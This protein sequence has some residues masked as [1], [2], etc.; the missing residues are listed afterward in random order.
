V[1]AAAQAA[2]DA[3]RP[4][5]LILPTR[6]ARDHAR[7]ELARQRGACDPSAAVTFTGLAFRVLGSRGP[8]LASARE[9]DAILVEVLGQE[10]LPEH[11][12]A[13]RFRGFRS[14][15]L[16]IFFQV[17]SNPIGS[18]HDLSRKLRAARLEPARV[19]RLVGVYAGYREV[20]KQ[21]GLATEPDVLRLAAKALGQGR[22]ETSVSDLL[23]LDGF[24]DLSPRQLEFLT[25]LSSQA[26]E[27][28]VT[29]PVAP[30]GASSAFLK[31]ETVREDLRELGFEEEAR[32]GPGPDAD[33]PRPPALRRLAERLFVEGQAP[34]RLDDP[35]GLHVVRAASRRDEVAYALTRVREFVTADPARRWT[36]ALVIVPQLRRYRALIEQVGGELE[37]PVRV[38]GPL[39]LASSPLGQGALALM[40]AAAGLDLGQVITAAACPS[41]GLTPDQAD[42]VA[43]SAR[44][45]GL[46]TAASE[47]LW[48]ELAREVEGPGGELLQRTLELG[49]A[50]REATADDPTTASGGR[51]L[52]R[53][54]EQLLVPVNP[55]LLGATP[56]ARELAAAAAEVSARQELLALLGD[57]ER[58]GLP[59]RAAPGGVPG[60]LELV[61]RVEEE[62]RVTDHQ[63]RD[64]RRHVLHVVDPRDA[65]AWEAE[66]VFVLGLVDGEFPR[67]ASDDLFLPERARRAL[68]GR[69]GR[70]QARLRLPTARDRASDEQFLFYAAVTRAQRELWLLYPGFTAS[71]DPRPHSRFL[72]AVLE[73]L[74]DEARDQAWVTRAPA[75]LAPGD[76][77]L[78][79]TESALR[80]FAYRQAAA[81]SRPTGPEQERAEVAVA[82]LDALLEQGDELRRAS[83]ALK[84]AEPSLEQPLGAKA[85]LEHVYSASELETYATCPFRH[86]VRH[87]LQVREADDLASS[88]LDARRQGVVVHAALQAVYAD[89]ADPERALEQAFAEGARSLEIGLEE[90]AFRRQALEAIRGFMADDARFRTGTDLQPHAFE[91]AFGPRAEAGP[92]EVHAP[93]LGGT[94]QLQGAIDRVDVL[95]ESDGAPR[96]FVTDY[97]LGGREV[98][99][100]YLDD[101]HKGERLQIPLYLL[102]LERVFG[103]RALGASFAALGTRRRTGIAEP[104]LAAEWERRLGDDAA[105][106]MHRVPLEPT[107]A[108]TEASIRRYVG[109]IASGLVDPLPREASDCDRCEAR[110]VCRLDPWEARRKARQGRALPLERLRPLEEEPA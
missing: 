87:L 73:E 89:H 19:E 81:I 65:R 102:A 82:V 6:A 22:A 34:E 79:L 106:R 105:V 21:R 55:A 24:M 42:A 36:D 31:L 52:R 76:A 61:A 50:L 20:L 92:L 74:T 16:R 78:L 75:D 57:L 11:E 44:R 95:P 56:G 63:P 49:R 23:L 18:A 47:A 30:A 93:E 54:F 64:R 15:L 32:P 85:A 37:V 62:L 40:R 38:R 13:L 46:P 39:A 27:T 48:E 58:L 104:P 60:P 97:K 107:L 98:D 53:A 1:L 43:R 4:F 103:M 41:L 33:D 71:G 26:G 69:L 84:S 7:N 28:V 66:A 9:R 2:L 45:R 17:D 8:R 110:D 101:M 108:R 90:D 91:L 51:L 59:L 35:Q 72:E 100:R 80:R 83:V 67:P 88:G 70:G 14:S 12:L 96:A 77:E 68:S 5:T 86:F 99:A 29:W 109:G 94:I 3:D 25:A 10:S